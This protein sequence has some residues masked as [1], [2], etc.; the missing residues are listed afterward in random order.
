MR[1]KSPKAGKRV[2]LE[3]VPFI[4][5]KLKF[6][7][8]VSVRNIFRYKKRFFMMRI[9]ISGCTAL[10][11]TGFGVKDSISGLGNQQFEEIQINDGS[12]ELKEAVENPEGTELGEKLAQA[13][14]E[15]AV[16]SEKTVDLV[17]N[18]KTKSINRI[19][20]QKPE[21]AGD[22]INL[23]TPD[24]KALPYPKKGEA[25]VN[26]K[27]ADTFHIKEGDK[28]I[29]RDDDFNEIEVQISGI[30]EN[31]VYNY[32]FI[33]P[34][35]YEEQLKETPEYKSIYFNLR[36]EM[37]AHQAAA[38]LMKLS[39]VSSVTLNKDTKERFDNMMSSLNYIVLLVIACAAA[40]A[41]IVL[42]NLSNINI[43]ER[44][45]EIATIK[46]LGF[47]RRE[48]SAYV[49]RENLV[50]TAIGAAAGLVLGYFLHGF[51]MGQIKV[52][53]VSFDVHIRP[54]SYLY[55]VLFTF[56]FDVAVDR[57][58]TLK[59]DKINMAE[60]LKSVE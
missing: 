16:V 30:C 13:A 33:S 45:R 57:I 1:P 2:F 4:W 5:K 29:L 19:I 53:M 11:V 9:G 58:M 49:F 3:R 55:S 10:L 23:H 38:N 20:F 21:E 26:N 37:D 59:L 12:A 43:T 17:Y 60:S 54:V 52:D 39:V 42:Y 6:L 47:Y 15:Y 46:V 32:I 22:Y 44:V 48:T 56:V 35:S 27:M 7:H 51:V 28:V 40:L 14:D 41:L 36:E 34:E 24:K 31:F 8:K 50:L 25:V 18:G